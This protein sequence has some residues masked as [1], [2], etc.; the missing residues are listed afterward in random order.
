MVDAKQFHR[1]KEAV[2]EVLVVLAVG[3]LIGAV[4]ALVSNLFVS[5]VEFFSSQRNS[6][7]FFT[8]TVADNEISYSPIIFLVSAAA[9]V[10]FIKT[11]LGVTKWA[12]PADAMYAAHQIKEPLDLKRGFASTLAAF[13]SASGGASVGQYGPLVHFGATMGIWVK[14][15]L[16][17]RL[18][19][20][21]YLGCGVAAAIS[22]GFNAPIA[23]VIFAHEAVLRH[24]S[25]RAIA[26]IAVASVTASALGRSWFPSAETFDI[27]FTVPQ[28]ME[29]VPL[30]MILGPILAVVAIVFMLSLR[31]AATLPAKLAL[32][33]LISPFLAAVICGTVGI[34]VPEILGLGIAD[35]NA[36]I[37]SQFSITLL[38]VVLILKILMTS[39]CIGLGLFG[40]VF[41]PAL[42]VGVAAG[43]LV[44]QIAIFFGV[45]D[46]SNVLAVVSMAAVS[47][48]V[49]GAPV[50]AVLIILELTQSYD[51]AVAAMLV[52]TIT[53]L[54]THRLFGHS[55][56]DRQLLDRSINLGLGRESIAMNQ[57]KIADLASEDYVRLTEKITGENALTKMKE[58]GDSEG[59]VV[60]EQGILLGKV[61][62]Y[63]ALNAGKESVEKYM[64]E[65]PLP[66]FVN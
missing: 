62:V 6:S 15:F 30:L 56:F 9:I 31:F 3:S 37:A 18:S 14:R 46:V 8:I 60:T 40:G 61:S 39:T 21:V 29:I 65:E 12:G 2:I 1:L 45:A 27:A 5:G 51:C 63:Q 20:D 54:L 11:V 22:A 33:P 48:A 49:I 55:F 42:F 26:P 19:H 36:M 50:A 43:A 38:L 64:D 32:N 41:S 35:M 7:T 47:S 28:L 44:G 10:V 34:F 17:G 23:G 66:L 58:I 52:V 59:Y 53:S 13:T 25:L 4:L 57:H 16:T 24:F